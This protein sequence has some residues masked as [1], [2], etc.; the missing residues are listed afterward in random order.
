MSPYAPRYRRNLWLDVEG[1]PEPVR[2]RAATALRVWGDRAELPTCEHVVEAEPAS[3]VFACAG[4]PRSRLRCA[5]CM[6]VH[7]GR[8][9]GSD[10]CSGCARRVAPDDEPALPLDLPSEW[11]RP[12]LVVGLGLCGCCRPSIPHPMRTPM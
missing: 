6:V 10:R 11:A 8:R 1:M 4:H 7:A 2:D 9:H 3:G 12:I 5:E